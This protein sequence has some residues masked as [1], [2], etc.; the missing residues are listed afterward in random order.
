MKAIYSSQTKLSKKNTKIGLLIGAITGLFIGL[1][2]GVT[3]FTI[4]GGSL[5]FA[6]GIVA[7]FAS[8]FAAGGTFMGVLFDLDAHE[9]N[10]GKAIESQPKPV[11]H[12]QLQLQPIARY[13]L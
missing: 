5:S 2:V 13:L 1:T 10:I 8:V 12:K 7:T 4:S 11:I 9:R 6:T 3:V